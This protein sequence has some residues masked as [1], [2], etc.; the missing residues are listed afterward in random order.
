MFYCPKCNN[1]YIEDLHIC[2]L[3]GVEMIDK[4]H[5]YIEDAEMKF[6]CNVMTETEAFLIRGILQTE[7]IDVFIKPLEVVMYEG[8]FSDME[9]AWGRLFV[10]TKDLENAQKI[11]NDYLAAPL[12]DDESWRN[13]ENPELLDE[14]REN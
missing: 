12:E 4:G 7:E 3:C 14:D 6:L 1:E 5:D 10:F 8:V 2:P 13:A 11:L 9:G